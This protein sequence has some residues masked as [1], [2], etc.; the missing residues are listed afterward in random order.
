MFA[1]ESAVWQEKRFEECQC[2]LRLFPGSIVNLGSERIARFKVHF[3]LPPGIFHSVASLLTAVNKKKQDGLQVWLLPW[4]TIDF[5][6]IYPSAYNALHLNKPHDC[7]LDAL[8]GIM[9]YQLCKAAY[10][11]R[12]RHSLQMLPL[13]G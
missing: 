10:L 2:T 4:R 6:I 3:S 12:G 7:A 9:P 1:I 11:G 13:P 5:R 8:L